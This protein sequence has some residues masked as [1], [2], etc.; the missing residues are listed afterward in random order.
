M[1]EDKARCF[2]DTYMSFALFEHAGS[3]VRWSAGSSCEVAFLC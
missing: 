1:W 2:L 3:Q